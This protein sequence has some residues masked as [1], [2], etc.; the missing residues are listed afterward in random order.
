MED[1]RAPHA[2]DG[3]FGRLVGS[4]PENIRIQVTAA[5]IAGSPRPAL[6]QSITTGPFL[7]SSTFKG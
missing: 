1:D 7:E 6:G 4:S 2:K 3:S 5:S